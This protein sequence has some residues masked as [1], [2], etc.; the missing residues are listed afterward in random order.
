MPVVNPVPKEKAA[1]E[2]KP[3]YEELGKKFGRMPN[4][5]AVMAHRPK[6]LKHFLPLYASVMAD[7]TLEAKY[8]ELAYL[9]TSQVNGCEY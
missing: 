9:K 8:K 1:E 2:V 7:G 5:F 6:V 3:I 4:V